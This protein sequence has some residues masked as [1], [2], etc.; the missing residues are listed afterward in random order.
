LN[1]LNVRR[2]KEERRVLDDAS[3]RI[4]TA[5]T[6]S[7]GIVVWSKEYHTGVVG[8][9]AQ[10]LVERFYR[11]AAVMGMDEAG[12]FKGSVRG[13]PGV[14]MVE[15]LET[16]EDLL[17]KFGGH[18]G[19]AGF[20]VEE[21]KVHELAARFAEACAALI[22]PEMA[23]PF[24]HA[25]AEITLPELDFPLVKEL[26]LF[27]PCGVGN[28]KPVLMIDRLLVQGYQVLK[29][30]HLKI[31]LTDGRHAIEG[32][33]WKHTSHPAVYPN[34]QVRVAFKPEINSFRGVHRI[35]AHLEAI[36]LHG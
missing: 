27:A 15:V 26:G 17:V 20:S 22:T 36:E 2:Q 29:D 4:I 14:N 3:R 32:L 6:V 30:A 12:I 9:V 1:D 19:A 21:A 31:R 8:I 34:A 18:A 16:C 28:R 23:E 35:Q 25:D 5:G 33:L 10:R 7:P 11:P 13:I 24:V